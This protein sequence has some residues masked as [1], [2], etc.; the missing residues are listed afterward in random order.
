MEVPIRASKYIFSDVV[1]DNAILYVPIGAKYRYEKTEPWNL[2]FDIVEMDFTGVEN[3]KAESGKVKT[4]YDLN[5][6]AVEGP[7]NG[8]Y[9]IDGKK[10]LI[11]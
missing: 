1:Y 3:V 4:I 8:I 7:T 11:K 2:F 9:I 6:C 10:V 5:G